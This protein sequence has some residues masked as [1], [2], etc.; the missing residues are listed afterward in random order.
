MVCNLMNK[1]QTCW[2]LVFLGHDVHISFLA[3]LITKWNKKINKGCQSQRNVLST[4]GI[5]LW[6]SLS[7]FFFWRADVCYGEH[8]GCNSQRFLFVHPTQAQRPWF[9]LGSSLWEPGEASGGFS[10][11]ASPYSVSSKS[12]ELPLQFSYKFEFMAPEASVLSRTGKYQLWLF[13]FISV[14]DCCVLPKFICDIRSWV[15]E[16]QLGIDAV[17]KV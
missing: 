8:F 4:A 6:L 3:S 9:F 5:R 1:S 15:F 7:L 17:M 2:G 13:W 11:L 14:M 12:L 10:L 16:K